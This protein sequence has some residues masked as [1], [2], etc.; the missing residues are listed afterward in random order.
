MPVSV[1]Y[2]DVSYYGELDEGELET[3]RP[4]RLKV[5]GRLVRHDDDV[6]VIVSEDY[7]SGDDESRACYVIPT[8]CVVEI[9]VLE[10]FE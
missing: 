6:I 4:C 2:D 5:Y 10:E 8:G 7:V 3:V 9:K 1:I